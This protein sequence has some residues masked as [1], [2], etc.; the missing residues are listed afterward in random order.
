MHGRK[1]RSKEGRKEGRKEGKSSRVMCMCA[2][3]R[4]CVLQ[5][6][7]ELCKHTAPRVGHD[8]TQHL[9]L[10]IRRITGRCLTHLPSHALSHPLVVSAQMYKRECFGNEI[11]ESICP[12]ALTMS[13]SNTIFNNAALLFRNAFIFAHALDINT[14]VGTETYVNE[15]L[16]CAT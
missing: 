12:F 6:P 8:R 9:R 3:W 1:E 15:S 2:G 10:P 4:Q 5:L 14:C 16:D 11:Q 13:D 7:H